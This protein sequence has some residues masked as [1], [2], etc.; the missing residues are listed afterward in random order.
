M[1]F[2]R[3]QSTA[4]GSKPKPRSTNH[5]TRSL[6]ESKSSCITITVV[7]IAYHFNN[8][9]SFSDSKH[10]VCSTCHKC[11]FNANHD[12][13]ITKF[14]KEVNS[15]AKTQSNKTRN[16][17]KPIQKSHTRKPIRQIF[18][19]HKFSPN[20]TSAVYE[21]TSPRSDLRWKPVGRIF[22]TIGLRWV[23]TGKILASYTTK[24]NSEPTHGS[25][26]DI[27]NIHKCKQ[28]SNLS[29]A[30]ISETSVEV[31]SKLIRQMIWK[32]YSILCSTNNSNG[33]NQVVSKSSDVPTADASDKHQQQPD[34]TSSTSTLATTV[35]TD[36]NFDL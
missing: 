22:N 21:K 28:T 16:N 30:D 8:S 18:K 10:F 14:L 3:F 31:D 35:T 9:N 36:G 19:R 2:A 29:A 11:I 12:A 13:Y 25:N 17:N 32:V 6:H 20:K 1:P 26:V 15:H 4:D 23:P 34:S 33:E 5:S 7:P 27:T 24:D